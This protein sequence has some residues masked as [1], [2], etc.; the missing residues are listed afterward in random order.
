M[1][2]SVAAGRRDE[3]TVTEEGKSIAKL[4][5]GVRTRSTPHHVDHRGS[6][7]EIYE[8]LNDYWDEPVVYA[9]QFSVRPGQVK[10]WGLHEHKRDRYTIISGEVLLFLYDSRP[11][12]PTHGASMKLVLS[13][14]GVR[15]VT[16]PQFVWHLSVNVG[17]T[18]AY[19]VNFPTEVYHHAAPDR[20]LLPYDSPE[21]PVDI[22]A[23]LPI[24]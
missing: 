12:S 5:D 10:G 13:D 1:D 21:I 7:F 16:I 9:Y 24:V 6:V 18:E 23:H 4:I 19:L 22:R 2:P 17:S 15:Q 8:G 3:Q 11:D 14:R 20:L